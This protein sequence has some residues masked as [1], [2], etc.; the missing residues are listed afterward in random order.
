MPSP[1]AHLSLR[2]AHRPNSLPVAAFVAAG[3]VRLATLLLSR[4]LSD[5][6][7]PLATSVLR[8]RMLDGPSSDQSV[9]RCHA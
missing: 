8:A 6:I 5:S 1:A 7:P 2:A 4:T 3:R 9:G